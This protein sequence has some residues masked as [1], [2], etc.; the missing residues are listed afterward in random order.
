MY[1]SKCG[2]PLVDG[3]CPKCDQNPVVNNKK[4]S[5]NHMT[6]FAIIL[7]VLSIGLLT[8][9][10]FALSSPKTIVL[11]SISNWSGLLKE[12]SNLEDDW[13]VQKIASSDKVGLK[14]ELSLDLGDSFQLDF[15]KMGVTLDYNDDKKNKESSFQA[16]LQVGKDSLDLDGVLSDNKIYTKIKDVLEP[17]YFTQFEYI[18]LFE[19]S[20]SIDSEKLVDIVFDNIKENINDKDFKKSKETV[21]LGDNAKKTNKI[22]YEVTSWKLSKVCLDILEDIKN[23]KDLMKS[24]TEIDEEFATSIDEAIKELKKVEKEKDEVLFYYNVY[25]YGFNNIVMEELS[26][27]KEAIQYYHYDNVHEFKIANIESNTN[28]FTLKTEQQKDKSFK[29][30]GFIVTYKYTGTY[31]KEEDKK[32]LSLTLELDSQQEIT[33]DITSNIKKLEDSYQSS[34]EI[35]ITGK[36]GGVDLGEKIKLTSNLTYTFGKDVVIPNIETAKPFEE[37]TEEEMSVILEKL[38]GHPIIKPIYDL[39]LGYGS[40]DYDRDIDFDSDMNFD[41]DYSDLEF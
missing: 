14:E 27:N 39:F 24:F 8:V 3:K 13:L 36:S 6:V 5:R 18:S 2:G 33:L 4:S 12:S 7:S 11:Q 25:Y 1:C 38:Q 20:D 35:V 10:F 30:S 41:D 15:G 16:K 37:I 31:K 32:S 23:D 19:N 9:G 40:M 22:S 28:F 21:F 34:G 26:D 17:Y 29:I